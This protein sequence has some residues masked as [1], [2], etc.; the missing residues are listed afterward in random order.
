[1]KLVRVIRDIEEE[2]RTYGEYFHVKKGTLGV[3]VSDTGVCFGR[4]VGGHSC[5]GNCMPTFGQF[6]KPEDIEWV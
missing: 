1:M 2:Q 4:D 5:R 6:M 3:K